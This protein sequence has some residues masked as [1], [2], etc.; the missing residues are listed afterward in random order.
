M[1]IGSRTACFLLLGVSTLLGACGIIRDIT[2]EL[3]GICTP[4]T[5]RVTS[6]QVFSDDPARLC[7]R[8]SGECTSLAQALNTASLCATGQ[9]V[10]LVADATYRMGRPITPHPS[11]RTK[12]LRVTR[13][14]GPIGLPV[15]DTTLTV[16][17][18]GATIIREVDD[19][20]ELGEFTSPFRFFYVEPE[21]KLT[22]T[23]LTLQNGLVYIRGEGDSFPLP[24]GGNL[25]LIS[26]GAIHNR[27]E[28]SLFDV[29][30]MGNRVRGPVPP[31]DAGFR[32][33][34]SLGG[35]VFN[36][37]TFSMSGGRAYDNTA[38]RGSDSFYNTGSAQF[39]NVRFE[40]GR[41]IGHV[42][43]NG[44]S[45]DLSI[46]RSTLASLNAISSSGDLLVSESLSHALIGVYGG[47]AVIRNSTV[48]QPYTGVACKQLHDAPTLTLDSV[49]IYGAR[50]LEPTSSLEGRGL[51]LAEQCT[52]TIKNTV[53]AASDTEDCSI[54]SPGSATVTTSGTNMDSDGS[55]PGFTTVDSQ[56]GELQD[57]G[58]PTLTRMPAAASPLVN[59]GGD[60]CPR[61]DQRLRPRTDGAC[62]VGAVER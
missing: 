10:S 50:D 23:N 17:G 21:G 47:T 54:S 30:L 49:T 42:L 9:T 36:S 4:D 32:Y 38:F 41:S 53:I 46:H 14:A 33:Y 11:L 35:A 22:L 40:G 26:G 55:C 15:V 61:T 34:A 13:H 5:L 52:V 48:D 59:A 39:A 12:Q 18:N 58:G 25:T 29:H 57:N 31:V 27:G 19:S 62:D 8:D 6:D 3:G 2:E 60:D 44:P 16:Q 43:N 28:L 56:L 37:G 7:S 24:R 1:R 51:K 45:G 20:G